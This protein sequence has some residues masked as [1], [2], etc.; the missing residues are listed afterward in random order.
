[1]KERPSRPST[2][3]PSTDVLVH[4]V[5]GEHQVTV[6]ERI[7]LTT[8]LGSCVAA[9]IRDPFAQVGGMNHF[10]L[11]SGESVEG[12][13]VQRFG[14]YSMELLINSLLRA[15][16]RRERLEAKLFGG[17]RLSENLPDIGAQNVAFAHQ[18]LER[19]NIILQRGCVGG[20]HARRVQFWP[21]SGR[22]RQLA[23]ARADNELIVRESRSRPIELEVGRV[24]L[25]KKKA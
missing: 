4:I 14:A 19:E 16:A 9:C 25:F 3:E 6:D 17:A 21:V 8:T 10:L 13:S 18:F 1:M 24:E 22:V 20:D 5:Q 7:V 11:P 2:G 23:L 12:T 15:G